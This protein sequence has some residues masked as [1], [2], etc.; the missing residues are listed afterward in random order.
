MF[1]EKGLQE[2]SFG[3]EGGY[4][5]LGATKPYSIPVNFGGREAGHKGLGFRV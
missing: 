5:S 4:F 1:W 2:S 3:G